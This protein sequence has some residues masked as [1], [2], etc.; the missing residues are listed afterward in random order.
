MHSYWPHNAASVATQGV[1][2]VKKTILVLALLMTTS[3]HALEA[4]RYQGTQ[5]GGMDDVL[6]LE[7]D[8]SMSL[9]LTR[10]VGGP[11]G[12]SNRGVVPYETSCRVKIWATTGRSLFGSFQYTVKF[13][14]LISS[15]RSGEENLLNCK[16]YVDE[17][18]GRASVRSMSFTARD[19]EF[20]R[21][22]N[23]TN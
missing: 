22:G 9:E 16:R 21:V 17:F 7:N 11:G 1:L 6:V 5:A 12:I 15:V 2:K 19:S 14:H 13:V 3:A 4:G 18:N 10:Q 8:G 20:K 23:E